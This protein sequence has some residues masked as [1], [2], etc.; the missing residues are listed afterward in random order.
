MIK[1][2][3]VPF[4]RYGTLDRKTLFLLRDE[5]FQLSGAALSVKQSLPMAG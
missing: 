2:R 5:R 3:G 4:D 1:E